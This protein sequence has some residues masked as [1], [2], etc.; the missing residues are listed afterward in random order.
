MKERPTRAVVSLQA[1]ARNLGRVRE[2]VGKNV[3]IMAVVKADAYGHGAGPVARTLI[4]AGAAW[5][6]V[7]L[8]EEGMELRRQGLQVPILVMGPTPPDQA[9]LLLEY[10]LDQMIPHPLVAQALSGS[11]RGSKARVR[12][13]LKI[14]TGMGRVG[15]HPAEAASAAR[16]IAGLRGLE[17]GGV[18]THFAAADALDKSHARGQLRRFLEAIRE[19]EGV[20]VS[21]PLRHAANSAAI[22][23]LPEA[24]L[25]MVRPGIALYGYPPSSREP[26]WDPV[27]T[28]QTCVAQIK[29]MPKGETVSY[30][31]TYEA[32][33]DI[34]VATLPVGYADGFSRLLSNRG[35]VLIRG[36]RA[37]V[38]GI[39]CM[40]MILVDVTDVRGVREGDEVILLGRQG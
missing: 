39:V 32:P 9:P 11:S 10:R 8:P 16:A 18:M 12:V 38:I 20:G 6:G 2:R 3:Q 37:P 30:G 40:D 14:D 26:S 35:E 4:E 25:D 19:I 23:E 28:F 34:L 31:C 33:R 7:A 24:Y 21:V 27:L 36:R 29:K 15:I 13:H 1:I 17:F 22:L 5:L